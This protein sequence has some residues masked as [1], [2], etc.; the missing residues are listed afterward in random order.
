MDRSVGMLWIVSGALFLGSSDSVQL[1]RWL[2]KGCHVRGPPAGSIRRA[3]MDWRGKHTCRVG[4]VFP[5]RVYIDSNHRDYRIWVSLVCGSHHI[6]NLMNLISLLVADVVLLIYLIICNSCLSRVGC[7]FSFEM[8]W[9]EQ[10]LDNK[11]SLLAQV[12]HSIELISMK[13]CILGVGCLW[14]HW[15]VSLAKL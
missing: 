11:D 12:W 5:G 9:L 1:C 4:Q 15:W 8:I 14:P 2:M 6:D 3:Y 10:K 13:P 7:I